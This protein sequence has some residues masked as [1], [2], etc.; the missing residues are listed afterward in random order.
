MAF[1]EVFDQYLRAHVEYFKYQTITTDDWK[2]FFLSYFHKQVCGYFIRRVYECFRRW[3]RVYWM[4]WSGINGCIHLAC[5]HIC[6]GTRL[7][8]Y[9]VLSAYICIMGFSYDTTLSA[10]CHALAEKWAKVV[11]IVYC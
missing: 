3:R 9:T 10:A 8:K 6:Q 2:K 5:R 7:I 4:K 1:V 11:T